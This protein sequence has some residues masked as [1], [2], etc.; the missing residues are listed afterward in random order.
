MSH[1]YRPPEGP[2]R[3]LDTYGLD[4]YGMDD[5]YEQPQKRGGCLTVFLVFVIGGNFIMFLQN[6]SSFGDIDVNSEDIY[7]PLAVNIFAVVSAIG[8]LE[9]KQWGYYGLIIAY[10]FAIAS[11]F[12]AGFAAGSFAGLIG[13][14]VFIM[15]MSSKTDMLE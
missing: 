9:W 12:S 6:L 7:I 10:M 13:L 4:S 1:S 14:A 11:N 2:K 15:L 3:K 5:D 8:L